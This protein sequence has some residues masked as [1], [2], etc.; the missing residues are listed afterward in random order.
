M[1]QLREV[2]IVSRHSDEAQPLACRARHVCRR[3]CSRHQHLDLHLR[4]VLR[5]HTVVRPFQLPMGQTFA[6]LG[7]QIAR[8]HAKAPRACLLA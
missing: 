4:H 3:L 1:Q 6:V 7:L 5:G 2:I 8:V